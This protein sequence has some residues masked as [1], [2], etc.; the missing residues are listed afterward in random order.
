MVP[1]L[2]LGRQDKSGAKEKAVP[3][4]HSTLQHWRLKR[5]HNRGTSVAQSVK[6]LTSA[7]V[8]IFQL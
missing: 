3:M 8:M 4:R 2:R 5:Q 7:Q 6:H 1:G